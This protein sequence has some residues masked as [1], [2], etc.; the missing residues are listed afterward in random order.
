MNGSQTPDRLYAELFDAVQSS[1]LFGDS[2]VFVD[3]IATTEPD[4]ILRAFRAEHDR[5]GFDLAEFVASHFE[6][7]APDLSTLAQPSD[8]PIQDYIEQ[9]WDQL[10][11]RAD[12]RVEHSSLIPLPN[13]YVV[14]GGRFRE[15][16]YWDS[17]FTMLGLAESGRTD[18]IQDMV[19]NFAWLIG[20]FGFIPNGNRT[21]YCTRSQPPFFTLMVDLLAE[22]TGDESVYA[23]FL[24]RLISEYAFWMAGVETLAAGQ[25]EHR[26]VVAGP[27]GPL[28]RY[29]DD[30]ATPRQESYA[31]DLELAASSGR[32]EQLY[33]DIRAG[34]ESGWDYSSRWLADRR[35]LQSIRTTRV[36]PV[37]LNSLLYKLEATLARA[38]EAHG[39]EADARKYR[40][41]ADNRKLLL[42][43]L[44]FDEKTG[45]F[46]DLALP[47]FGV[48]GTLSIAA[49]YPLFFGI[50]TEEQA[51]RVAQCIQRDYLKAGGW[52][53]S[54]YATGQQWDSPNGWAPMQWITYSGLKRYGFHEEAHAGA[55]RWVDNSI[56]V[57]REH[58]C[59]LEKYNVIN[60]GLAGSGGEYEVQEGF[61][62]T[63]AVL[64]RLMREL[65]STC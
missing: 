37:D 30:A 44:F 47:D 62:G 1:R 53:T 9:L 3:A 57:Y 40:A 52:V 7:P 16:Y 18:L 2:K 31:E 61:G 45:M 59:L 19:E 39:S 49:A 43:K 48:T 29:W 56:A 46:M 55:T 36:I 10:T 38:S 6:L 54:N 8:L 24:P 28:N 11:R 20:E 12:K 14:P 27:D 25:T 23:R 58:G 65:R 34:A 41:R 64:L 33:R 15:V 50:A 26:R 51:E 22:V 21:Y 17:Y 4:E 42:Q 35:T 13:R 32:P 63:N 60:C 5:P